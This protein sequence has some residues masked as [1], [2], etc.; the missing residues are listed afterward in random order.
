LYDVNK[1]VYSPLRY[2]VPVQPATG[3]NKKS[4]WL[5]DWKN[6]TKNDFTIAEEVT[7]RGIHKKHPDLPVFYPELR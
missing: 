6:P 5:T 4:V 3:Q 7:I 2:G 1:E